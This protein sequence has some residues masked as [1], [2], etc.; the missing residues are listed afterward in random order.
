MSASG[1]P[2]RVTRTCCPRPTAR[3]VALSESFNSRTPISL[4]WPHYQAMGTQRR[5]RGRSELDLD[6]KRGGSVGPVRTWCRW[7]WRDTGSGIGIRSRVHRCQ[8]GATLA[9]VMPQALRTVITPPNLPG[10][11]NA[12]ERTRTS[13]WFPRHGPE[14]CASTNSATSACVEERGYRTGTAP[15]TAGGR[16]VW[17]AGP[18]VW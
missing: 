18:P 1:R 11:A 17:K 8:S 3:N 2:R 7:R 6:C 14:P 10:V 15:Q 12:D 5:A 16:V 4:M 13:T 9:R